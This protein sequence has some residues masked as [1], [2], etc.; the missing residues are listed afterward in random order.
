MKQL[1]T[2]MTNAEFPVFWILEF[3]TAPSTSLPLMV[4]AQL[5]TSMIET[6]IQ[7]RQISASG[8]EMDSTRP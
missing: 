6:R 3:R 8:S 1:S 5:V 2:P 7:R 4:R